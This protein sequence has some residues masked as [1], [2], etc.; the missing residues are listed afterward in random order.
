M[1]EGAPLSEICNYCNASNPMLVDALNCFSNSSSTCT[2][3]N[4]LNE[5]E[6][7]QCVNGFPGFGHDTLISKSA[8]ILCLNINLCVF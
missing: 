3:S 6:Q 7:I 1:P 8:L 4:L 2:P 5:L